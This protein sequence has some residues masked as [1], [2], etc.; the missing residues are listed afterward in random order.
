MKI[1][2]AGQ[3][4]ELDRYTIANEPVASIDLM[5]R[6]AR[7]VT[8]EV[9]ARWDRQTRFLIFAG[10]G[11]N[12][13]DA[14]AVARLL[15]ERG[16]ATHTYLF[17]TK[18]RLS[19]DCRT[20]SERLANTPGA[21]L[22]IIDT[23][24]D[25]PRVDARDVLID[26][27]FGTGLNKPL[28]GGFA[29][30]A[31]MMSETKAPVVSIDMPSGLMDEDNSYND[32]TNV[33]RATLTLTLQTPKT[34]FFFAENQRYI[35]EWK[36]LDIGLSPEGIAQMPCSL[37]L[38]E[39]ADI[40]ALL[41]RRNAFAHKGQMGHALLVCGSYGMA[42]A[43]ILAARA[44]LRSGAGKL[45]VHTP[46]RNLP[47]LQTAVPEA[48]VSPDLD[49]EV[50]TQ[51]DLD[52]EGFRATGVGPGLG[53]ND[54]TTAAFHDLLVRETEPM[55][56]DAD[57]LTML[58]RH[59][60]YMARIPQGSLL[61]PHPKELEALTGHCADSFERMTKARD[62][63][64]RHNLYVLVKGHYSLI[65][66]PS[67]TVWINPTGNAGMATAGCGD[68]LTGLLTGLLAQGYPPEQAMR[69]GVWLHGRAGDIAAEQLCEECILAG[70][71]IKALPQAFRQLKNYAL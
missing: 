53:L 48:I 64:V 42:G 56:I 10:P 5:E 13:G 24:F 43:A 71:L 47:L 58:G 33:V 45:T 4:R 54:V 62:F 8:D 66:S 37:H 20:N 16:Y 18:G 1:F 44:C 26:G 3:L 51:V 41:R 40:R 52:T 12:G 35:G 7:A 2:S 9:A 55:V 17:N 70:D 57:A 50:V 6:A 60:H 15:T 30:L 11:N 32:L 27:L 19:D 25:F 22:T 28:N 59:P 14:L 69:I 38:T 61:T 34:A 23:H 46:Q 63:A 31:R 68:V 65:C 29:C 21:G 39:T 49:P 36:V 67:G